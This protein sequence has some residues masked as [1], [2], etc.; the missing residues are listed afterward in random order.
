MLWTLMLPSLW[1]WLGYGTL[2]TLGTGLLWFLVDLVRDPAAGAT[3]EIIGLALAVVST[4]GSLAILTFL[5]AEW[6]GLW[7]LVQTRLPPWARVTFAVCVL[8]AMVSMA[9]LLPL[10]RNLV[11]ERIE[12]ENNAHDYQYKCLAA[13]PVQSTTFKGKCP[14][15]LIKLKRN[16]YSVA[17]DRL[18]ADYLDMA[19]SAW[20]PLLVTALAAGGVHMAVQHLTRSQHD[21]YDRK[22]YLLAAAAAHRN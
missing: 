19:K 6:S 4:L 12:F 18:V 17:H 13:P 15:L 1:A 9:Y 5:V 22:L 8:V 11:I 10:Y 2:A 14:E 21:A 20:F 3:L 7:R 16:I